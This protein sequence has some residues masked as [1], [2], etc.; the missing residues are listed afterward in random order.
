MIGMLSFL[1]TPDA[2]NERLALTSST[3]VAIVLY[4]ISLVASV[5]A[6]GYLTFI[7]KFMIATYVVVF[8][9]LMISVLLMV[10]KN[11]DQMDKA[12]KLHL[13]TRWVIPF[14]WIILNVVVFVSEL[15]I[16]YRQLILLGGG[17]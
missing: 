14:A 8:F 2:V 17:V 3:L 16:P 13:R 11:N 7:D 15:I 9:S 1:M 12:E 10:Y 4:H 5:P 6:T